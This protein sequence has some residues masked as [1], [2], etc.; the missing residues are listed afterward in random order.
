MNFFPPVCKW[1]LPERLLQ[2]SLQEMALD[3]QE[4]NEGIC[5]WL[6][7]RNDDSTAT[8]RRAVRL[9]GRGIWKTPVN[10][11]IA[12]ELLRE[13]HQHARSVGAILVGQIHSHGSNY[14]V[15]LSPTDI[16]YGVAVPYYLSAVAPDY[17]LNPK[18]SWA[19]CGIHIYYPAEG[20]LRLNTN[21]AR[22]A[23]QID[24]SLSLS[25][26]TINGI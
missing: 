24:S 18:T 17:G 12:P 8:V 26:V 3:G 23:L 16:R 5:L 10:I 19:D 22:N 2:V 14:G 1:K 7:D 21:D 9:R 13:V 4:G 15:D 25:E 6:G 11:R 20:F